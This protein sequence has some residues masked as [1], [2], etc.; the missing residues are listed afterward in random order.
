MTHRFGGLPENIAAFCAFLRR[1]HGFR[2]GPRELVDAAHG[3]EMADLG[4]E[5]EVRDILRTILSKTYDDVAVFDAAFARFFRRTGS[6]MPA[7]DAP[8][9]RDMPAGQ[10]QP[11]REGMPASKTPAAGRRDTDAG[12][13]DDTFPASTVREIAGPEGEAAGALLRASYSPLEAEGTPLVLEPPSHDWL[14]AAAALARRVHAGASRRWSPSVRGP[15]FDFRRTLRTSLRT[16]GEPVTPRWRAHPRRRPRFVLLID[17]SRSMS[18][19]AAPA[20]RTAVALSAVSPNTETFTFS[21]QLRRVTREARRAAAGER[22]VLDVDQAWG[23]GTTIGACLGEFVLHFGERLLGP[24]AVVIIASDGLDVG[25]PGLLKESMDRIARRSAAVVW[26]NPL[27]DT[28]GY[29]PTA[30]GMNVARPYASV[31]TSVQD[32]GGLRA[33]AR[34]LRVG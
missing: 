11:G 26:L 14:E 15:R 18:E 24:D 4:N 1:D 30:A 13:I 16:G 25:S 12:A 34:T 28:A 17:G 32:P 3:L 23:G 9:R 27:L 21:T 20:L 2:I 33:L 22:R 29:E 8:G 6:V 31:L 5:R 19:S 10:E 7:L